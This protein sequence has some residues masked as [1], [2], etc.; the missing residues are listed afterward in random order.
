[1]PQ[2]WLL[3]ICEAIQKRLRFEASSFL[4]GGHRKCDSVKLNPSDPALAST[5]PAFI[6]GYIKPIDGE[7]AGPS[8]LHKRKT[9]RQSLG[10]FQKGGCSR[11]IELIVLRGDDFAICILPNL[12]KE[13]NR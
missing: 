13:V 10:V 5:A 7:S 11:W 4:R 8:Y 2:Y 12:L 9:P 3:A 6:P 1:M